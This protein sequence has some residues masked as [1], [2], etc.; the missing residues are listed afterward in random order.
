MPKAFIL[1]LQAWCHCSSIRAWHSPATT[2]VLRTVEFLWEVHFKP[3]YHCAFTQQIAASQ[4]QVDWTSKCAQAFAAKQ[5]LTSSQVLV[6]YDPS[7]P[8]TLAGDASAYGIGAIISH[9]LPNGSEWPI[10][11]ASRTL[12][13]SEQ[14]YTQLEEEAWSLV[15]RS[16]TSNCIGESLHWW[17]TTNPW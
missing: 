10:A 16:F 9:T 12:I 11:F 3:S 8:I 1:F 6:H 5:A 7:L 15:S 17:L 2:V 14:N 13:T 4:C